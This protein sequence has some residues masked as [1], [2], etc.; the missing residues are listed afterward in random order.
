MKFGVFDHVDLGDEPISDIYQGRLGLAELADQAGFYGYHVAEH[1]GTLHGLL[2]SPNL[3]LAALS[4]RTKNIRIGSLV[5]LL[6]LYEPLRLVE[7][8]AMLDQMSGGRLQIGVGRGISPYEVGYFGVAPGE[9]RARFHEVLDFVIDGLQA[10]TITYE[11]PRFQYYDVPMVQPPLQKPYPP[12]WIGAHSE[13]SLDFAAEYGCNVVIG[14][15]NA[16]AKRAVEYY[17]EAWEAKAERRA[18]RNSPVASPFVSAW[19][20]LYVTDTDEEALARAE[21]AFDMHQ[22]RL[23]APSRAWGYTPNVYMDKYQTALDLGIHFAGS[24][25]TIVDKISRDIEKT[26]VN[27]FML[28]F[29]WG[30]L[31]TAESIRSFEL[32]RDEVLPHLADAGAKQAAE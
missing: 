17:P 6:P 14:G 2:H 19:R 25:E 18:A 16:V 10:E 22:T 12:L 5:N 7:E 20:F 8:Y 30:N 4:Q 28:S 31:K 3:Y 26:G 32:F 23:A 11:S 27:Y 29:T 13:R 15:P 9:S 1:H 21:P 24:P